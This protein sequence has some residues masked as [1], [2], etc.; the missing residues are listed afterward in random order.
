MLICVVYNNSNG[1]HAAHTWFSP[2]LLYHNTQK[3]QSKQTN[4]QK[5]FEVHELRIDMLIKIRNMT[6]H[7]DHNQLDD[8]LPFK[9]AV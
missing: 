2:P 1:G 9:I 6:T 5:Q 7:V 3:Q 8:P 4:K